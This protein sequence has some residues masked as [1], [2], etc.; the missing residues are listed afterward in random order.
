MKLCVHTCVL[1][2][3]IKYM[4][5]CDRGKKISVGKRF[6]HSAVDGIENSL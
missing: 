1:G 4:S 5:Y 2:S 6:H 3:N